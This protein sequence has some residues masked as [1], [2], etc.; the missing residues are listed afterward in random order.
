MCCCLTFASNSDAGHNCVSKLCK[1]TFDLDVKFLKAFHLGKKV[2][3]KCRP[4]LVQFEKENTKAKIPGKS[5]LL[6]S[7]ELYSDI[8]VSVD[9]TKSK[10]T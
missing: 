5:Y 10:R 2:L 6:K 3:Y 7:T 1:D 8:Y 4:L 9:I